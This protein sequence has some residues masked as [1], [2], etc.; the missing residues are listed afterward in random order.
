MRIYRNHTAKVA[1]IT[2]SALAA[3]A[4]VLFFGQAQAA[5]EL[6]CSPARTL[7]GNNTP[8]AGNRVIKTYVRHSD[9]GW[10][11]FHTLA[12]EAIIDRASQYSIVD[13]SNPSS[14]DQWT[15]ALQRNPNL[16]MVG[17]IRTD[18]RNGHY[19]YIEEIY[20]NAKGGALVI[21]TVAECN[22][23][24]EIASTQAAGGPVLFPHW[25]NRPSGMKTN[26]PSPEGSSLEPP[27]RVSGQAVVS[28]VSDGGTF[29]VPVTINDQ[30]T[31]KFVVDSGA[32]D[33]SIPTD[34]VSTLTRTGTIAESDF[35][36]SQTYK[37][38]DGST[39]PSQRFLIRSLKV[40]NRTLENV[41]ASIAPVAGQLLLG[42]SFLRRFKSWAID[43]GRPALILNG[44]PIQPDMPQS[45]EPPLSGLLASPSSE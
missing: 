31:L 10:L 29:V 37:L 40:G 33:V 12:S 13:T 19:Y 7:L 27:V 30:L 22:P 5:T 35:I 9:G 1:V 14:P 38:A 11:V 24:G 32:S 6:N 39:V 16:T 25:D 15:G 18:L 26:R 4:M 45:Q 44:D 34:V 28:M 42:Q 20:D 21:K 43:N 23:T 2:G 41:T 17:Q 36:G 3:A 8:T